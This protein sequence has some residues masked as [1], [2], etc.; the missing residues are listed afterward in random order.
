[1]GTQP[2]APIPEH[3]A[4]A[5]GSGLLLDAQEGIPEEDF[6]HKKHNQLC[7]YLIFTTNKSPVSPEEPGPATITEPSVACLAANAPPKSLLL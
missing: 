3:P 5:S 6:Y 7:S 4:P 1:M 2:Q